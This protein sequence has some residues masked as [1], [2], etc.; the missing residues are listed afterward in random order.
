MSISAVS[1]SI[2]ISPP[3]RSAQPARAATPSDSAASTTNLSQEA[4]A[5]IDQ[6]KQRDTEVRQHE[7]AHLAAAGGLATSGPTYTYQRGP[8]G[9][10]YAVGGEVNIDTSPGATPEETIQR[11]RTIAAAALAPAEPSGQDRAVAA[12]AQ[13][14][15]MQARAELAQ[16]QTQRAYGNNA[17][18]QPTL[19]LYA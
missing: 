13:Q 11:A 2:A 9:V 10:S 1:A 3:L 12:E 8:N 18:S 16:Q 4:L 19:D 5:M 6:L 14:M 15:E 7:Q 17:P